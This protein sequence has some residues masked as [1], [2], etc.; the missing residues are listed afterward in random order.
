MNKY[1]VFEIS[2]DGKKIIE[3]GLSLEKAES[4]SQEIAKSNLEN[5]YG[6]EPVYSEKKWLDINGSIEI[7]VDEDTFNSEFLQW[8]ESKG[9]SFF[10]FMKPTEDED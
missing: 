4:L 8:L 6:Y 2:K 1:Q 3:S 7:D 10:G 9:W 5:V